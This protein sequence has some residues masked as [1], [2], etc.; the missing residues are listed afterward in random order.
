MRLLGGIMSILQCAA[1]RGIESLRFY[2]VSELSLEISLFGVRSRH[3]SR[4][5]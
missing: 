3:H 2:L 5:G 4:P 1:Y